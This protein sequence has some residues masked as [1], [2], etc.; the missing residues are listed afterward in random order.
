MYFGKITTNLWNNSTAL[1]E[2]WTSANG[3]GPTFTQRWK[4]IPHCLLGLYSTE[5]PWDG[6][7]LPPPARLGVWI[8]AASG[9]H[10]RHIAHVALTVSGSGNTDGWAAFL[11][12]EHAVRWLCALWYHASRSLAFV[13]TRCRASTATLT[14]GEDLRSFYMQE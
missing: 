12:A 13:Q 9:L 2:C 7:G 5:S 3:A 6:S 11:V 1:C 10:A 14:P 8:D 4:W